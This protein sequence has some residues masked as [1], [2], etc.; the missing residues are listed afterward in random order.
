MKKYL[1]NSNMKFIIQYAN[2]FIPETRIKCFELF[3]FSFTIIVI[4]FAG[5]KEKAIATKNITKLL[6][7]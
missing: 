5:I 1:A 4:K 6:L 3:I 7:V 2:I